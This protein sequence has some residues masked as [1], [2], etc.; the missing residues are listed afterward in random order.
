MALNCQRGG[1]YRCKKEFF[2]IL[3]VLSQI[4]S[5]SKRFPRK[6]MDVPSLEVLKVRLDEVLSNLVK[7]KVSLTM[8]GV[9][10][11]ELHHL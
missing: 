4:Q 3:R 9:A 8:L 6:V 5:V 2:F 10:G 11:L 7:R 1:S